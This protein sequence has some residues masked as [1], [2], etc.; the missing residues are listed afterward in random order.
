MK[1]EANIVSWGRW[2]YI[3]VAGW[4]GSM[5]LRARRNQCKYLICNSVLELHLSPIKAPT[6]HS[7]GDLHVVSTLKYTM[8][9]YVVWW[10]L[11]GNS[12][13]NSWRASD[14]RVIALIYKWKFAISTCSTFPSNLRVLYQWGQRWLLPRGQ[15]TGGVDRHPTHRFRPTQDYTKIR[16]P[17]WSSGNPR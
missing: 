4:G 14:I 5:H 17:L 10:F 15:R 12:T 9:N 6:M 8:S 1:K 13:S 2:V 7:R 3:C 16:L 11:R